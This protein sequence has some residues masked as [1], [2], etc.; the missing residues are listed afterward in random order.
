MSF[1]AEVNPYTAFNK[2]TLIISRITQKIWLATLAL[3]P[4][5]MNKIISKVNRR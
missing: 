1:L 3:P 4:E 5:F 2:S